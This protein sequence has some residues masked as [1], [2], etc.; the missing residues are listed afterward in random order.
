MREA[1]LRAELSRRE[2]LEALQEFNSQLETLLATHRSQRAWKVMLWL[3]KAYTLLFRKS[4][5]AFL[6]FLAATP[7]TGGGPLETYE[8]EFPALNSYLPRDFRDP[9]TATP[10]SAEILDQARL[11]RRAGAVPLATRYDIL[12]LPVF[13]FDF[14]LDRPQ[15]LAAHF[16]RAGHRVFWIC[17][18][19]HLEPDSATPYK[20][21]ERENNLWEVNIRGRRLDLQA[22]PADPETAAIM[23]G[24]IEKLYAEC[25]ISENCVIVQW[26]A[27]HPVVETL[28]DRF[29]ARILYD[30]LEAGQPTMQEERRLIE[31][32]DVFTVA[33]PALQ[34]RF[35]SLGKPPIVVRNA[36]DF[37]F[38]QQSAQTEVLSG[39]PRPVVGYVGSIADGTDPDLVLEAARRR[40]QYTFVLL[41]RNPDQDLAQLAALENVRILGPRP[42]QEMPAYLREF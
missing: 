40:P 1:L 21:L 22:Q 30:C 11:R 34:A 26:P 33:A 13:P 31:S 5:T 39:V 2:T 35:A 20:L 7:F 24:S 6:R 37:D 23:L 25:G 8:P 41:G 29:G 32:S 9:F 4:K 12:L 17:P 3:R 38:F 27:W 36:A 16:A 19:V 28:R 14:R 18:S 42:Y 15:Q 10:L